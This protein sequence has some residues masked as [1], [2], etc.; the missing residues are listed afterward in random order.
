MRITPEQVDALRDEHGSLSEDQVRE[1][2]GPKHCHNVHAR[3]LS[4][5]LEEARGEGVEVRRHQDGSRIQI[6]GDPDPPVYHCNGCQIMSID[7]RWHTSG[8]VFDT[9]KEAMA[10]CLPGRRA[11]RTSNVSCDLHELNRFFQ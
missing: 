1:L 6:I 4:Y 5:I 11:K 3:K 8:A 9:L 10:E 7:G 2:V